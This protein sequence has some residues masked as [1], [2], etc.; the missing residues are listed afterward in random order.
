MGR[1]LAIPEFITGVCRHLDTMERVEEGRQRGSLAALAV[2][3]RKVS[4]YALD[5]LWAH[6]SSVL[7][8]LMCMPSDLWDENWMPSQHAVRQLALKRPIQPGDWDRVLYYAPRIQSIQYLRTGQPRSALPRM[9]IQPQSAQ[10]ILEKLP[11]HHITPN[12]RRLCLHSPRLMFCG[13]PQLIPLFPGDKLEDVQ[14]E[15][16]SPA[17][18]LSFVGGAQ[19]IVKR[20]EVVKG[21]PRCTFHAAKPRI[22]GAI[23]AMQRLEVLSIPTLDPTT[24]SHISSLPTLIELR[25]HNFDES[26]DPSLLPFLNSHAGRMVFPSLRRLKVASADLALVLPL[27]RSFR[28]PLKLREL[29]ISLLTPQTSSSWQ[30]LLHLLPSACDPAHLRALTLAEPIS[31]HFIFNDQVHNSISD[32]PLDAIL[33]FPFL[34]HVTIAVFSLRPIDST[35]LAMATRWSASLRSFSMSPHAI[36]GDGRDSFHLAPILGIGLPNIWHDGASTLRCLLPFGKYC[37]NLEHLDL[38]VELSTDDTNTIVEVPD[39]DDLRAFIAD[40][41]DDVDGGTIGESGIVSSSA[42]RRHASSA[43]ASASAILSEALGNH[44]AALDLFLDIRFTTE[45]QAT[46]AGFISSI[47]HNVI[48]MPFQAKLLDS[49]QRNYCMESRLKGMQGTST[50]GYGKAIRDVKSA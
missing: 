29:T 50:M 25:L 23:R 9:I 30:T 19:C 20:L 34:T 14:M 36:K 38:G 18:D 12:L 2:V 5:V 22:F 26:T 47:F 45:V 10:H 43:S 15:C 28:R 1:C 35:L 8:L 3:C 11:L 33:A 13:M 37:P 17:M 24:L 39:L 32:V 4:P 6:L 16:V 49:I 44:H 46:I 40:C 21:H 48:D 7:P 27:L 42:T 41:G 31:R